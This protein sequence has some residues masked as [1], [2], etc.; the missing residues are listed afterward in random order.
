VS[1]A[2]ERIKA[3]SGRPA[4]LGA[5]VVAL[6]AVLFVHGQRVAD[7]ADSPEAH[8]ALVDRFCLDCH[9]DA[10][11]SGDFT[12]QAASVLH[13]GQDPERWEKVVRK[14]RVGMMPPPDARQPLAEE[15]AALVSWLE[16]RLDRA[17]DGAPDP[18]PYL[19]RR[20]N[21]AEYANAI[22]DLLNVDVDSTAMLP[23]DDAA[24]GFDNIA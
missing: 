10:D 7:R 9:N 17:A 21:R 6:V 18:G 5:A 13:A 15:R 20:L 16:D 24:Y 23:P 22:R 1:P 14:L 12:L 11:R 8:Q 19:T 4:A 3:A 2:L